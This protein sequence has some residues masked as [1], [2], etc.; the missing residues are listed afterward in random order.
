MGLTEAC[1]TSMRLEK[2]LRAQ[3]ASMAIIIELVV[4]NLALAKLSSASNWSSRPIRTVDSLNH[5]RYFVH[6]EK[7]Q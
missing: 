3:I 7:T 6:S 2:V 4:P 5:I 1:T